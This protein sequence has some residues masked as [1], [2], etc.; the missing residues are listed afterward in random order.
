MLLM[1]ASGPIHGGITASASRVSRIHEQIQ[2]TS[3]PVSPHQI[4]S[5]VP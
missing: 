5:G 1:V 4:I 2:H 3:R